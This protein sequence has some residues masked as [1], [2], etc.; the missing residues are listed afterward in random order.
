MASISKC[1]VFWLYLGLIFIFI[2]SHGLSLMIS[3]D[4]KK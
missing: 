1:T 3:W 2:S 4:L